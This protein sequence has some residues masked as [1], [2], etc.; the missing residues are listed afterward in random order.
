M[1]FKEPNQ[2]GSNEVI[3]SL[4]AALKGCR[5]ALDSIP[6]KTRGASDAV[7]NR[8]LRRADRALEKAN[9]GKDAR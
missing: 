8:A 5:D 1:K 7:I 6:E 9:T 2:E 4:V 3:R